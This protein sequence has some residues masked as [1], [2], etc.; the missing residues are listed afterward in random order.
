MTEKERDIII[1]VTGTLEFFYE[2][3]HLLEEKYPK[4]MSLTSR[5]RGEYWIKK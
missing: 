5:D 4:Q 1:H 3:R 2:V